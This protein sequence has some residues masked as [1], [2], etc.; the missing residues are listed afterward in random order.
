M[1]RSGDEW[2]RAPLWMKELHAWQ[3]GRHHVALTMPQ[4]VSQELSLLHEPVAYGIEGLLLLCN[5]VVHDAPTS[6]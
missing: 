5:K 4:R 3:A 6:Q 1:R 2:K